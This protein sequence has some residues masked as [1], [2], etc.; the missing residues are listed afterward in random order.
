[1]RVNVS[2]IV[3]TEG[4][5]IDVNYYGD[6]SG[7]REFDNSVD[8]KPSFKFTGRIVNLGGLLKLSGELH[9]EFVADCLR[10]LERI[11][12]VMDIEV[13]E[14]FVEVIDSDEADAYIYE[15]NVVDI[16]KPLIDNILLAM[17]TKIICSDD[18]KGLCKHCGANLNFKNCNCDESKIVDSRMEILK[19]FF[20]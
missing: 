13:K 6:L 8:F 20:K 19:D 9:F 10:C 12:T 7:L 5:G 2:D 16:E 14:V 11:E 18:C 17:P 4:A 3:K 15:G 1:M